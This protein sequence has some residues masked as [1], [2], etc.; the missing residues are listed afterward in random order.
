MSGGLAFEERGTSPQVASALPVGIKHGTTLNTLHLHGIGTLMRHRACRRV[1][2]VG[3]QAL[4]SLSFSTPHSSLPTPPM[5]TRIFENG[6]LSHTP[7]ACLWFPTGA[8]GWRL[9]EVVV[10]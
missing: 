4:G 10:Q 6:S 3:D 2:V 8:G 5:Q 1:A 7:I 9:R